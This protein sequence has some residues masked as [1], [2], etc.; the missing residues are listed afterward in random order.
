MTV[1]VVKRD[2]GLAAFKKAL[3]DAD[4]EAVAVGIHADAGV[5]ADSGLTMAELGAIHEFGLGN[6][7]E[8]SFLRAWGE[9]RGKA[10]LT[11]RADLIESNTKAGNP[12]RA[13]EQIGLLAVGEIQQRISAGIPPANTAETIARKGSSIPLIDT[14]ALRQSITHKVVRR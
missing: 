12:R 13:L 1:R 4:A 11:E 14:G 6:V 2:R 10:L 9:S 8:R 3:R 7:P 5:H